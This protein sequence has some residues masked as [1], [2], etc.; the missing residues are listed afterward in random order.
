MLPSDNAKHAT[1]VLEMA[2][3]EHLSIRLDRLLAGVER[4]VAS[5]NRDRFLATCFVGSDALG[6]ANEVGTTAAAT[7][8]PLNQAQAR[9]L[10]AKVDKST[11]SVIATAVANAKDSIAV[12]DWNDIKRITGA[13][14]WTQFSKAIGGLH[15]ALRKID[16]VRKDAVLVWEGE[17]WIQAAA[18]EDDYTRGSLFIDGPAVDSLRKACGLTEPMEKTD[19]GR[20]FKNGDRVK[21]QPPADLTDKT[22]YEGTIRSVR[23]PD[24]YVVFF[25]TD[26]AA[27]MYD[28]ELHPA[29]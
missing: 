24:E 2:D 8:F 20:R 16:R 27:V 29:E 19:H 18:D 13:D 15:R 4:Y 5:E 1:W 17:V 28:K 3:L 14:N 22:W 11:F 25:E 26:A 9:A 10:E 23:G 7:S 6:P 12:I 21:A